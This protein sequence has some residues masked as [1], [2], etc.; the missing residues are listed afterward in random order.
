MET[1]HDLCEINGDAWCRGVAVDGI[2]TGVEDRER[3]RKAH[4]VRIMFSVCPRIETVLKEELISISVDTER[5]LLI[6]RESNRRALLVL[7]NA[8]R[9]IAAVDNKVAVI[10]HHT[11]PDKVAHIRLHSFVGYQQNPA[12]LIV[13][14]WQ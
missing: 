9:L 3:Y 12:L 5:Y 13:G 2:Q 4:E 1:N 14:T 11:Q 10:I 8:V 7:N 6:S